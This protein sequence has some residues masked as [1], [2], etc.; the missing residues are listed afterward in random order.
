MAAMPGRELKMHACFLRIG[1]TD[2][3]ARR[4]ACLELLQDARAVLELVV[5]EPM[6]PG[7]PAATPRKRAPGRLKSRMFSIRVCVG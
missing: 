2:E 4:E 1:R 7:S 5:D 6:S 3:P